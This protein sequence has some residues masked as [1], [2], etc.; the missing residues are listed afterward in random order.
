MKVLITGGL[1]FIGFHTAIKLVDQ[2]YDVYIVDNKATNK[3]DRIAGATFIEGDVT[4]A[5]TFRDVPSVDWVIHLAGQT[6]V[7][8]SMKD[9]MYDFIQNVVGTLNVLNYMVRK[10]VKGIVFA[11]TSAIYGEVVNWKAKE[12]MVPCP[13]SFY[14]FSKLTAEEYIRRYA[15]KYKLLYVIFRWFNIYGPLKWD[16]VIGIF[17]R[18]TVEGKPLPI[19]NPNAVRDYIYISDVVDLNSKVIEDPVPGLYNVGTG[20]PTK[21]VDLAKIFENKYG[22]KYVSPE[23]GE[24]EGIYADIS[25]IK[26]FYKF[27]PKVNLEE[28]IS[29]TMEIYKSLKERDEK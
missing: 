19:R 17:T 2:G 26:A 15:K 5:R 29:A 16:N 22:V 7:I 11:S 20:V 25:R 21:I 27:I 13:T 28:G 8:D 6:K 3:V 1:G 24:I 4:S 9:P 14:G 12:T 10:K 18:C 23:P